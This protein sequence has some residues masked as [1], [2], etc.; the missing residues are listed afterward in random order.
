VTAGLL[1]ARHAVAGLWMAL[2]Q[3]DMWGLQGSWWGIARFPSKTV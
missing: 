3:G 2:P 1:A